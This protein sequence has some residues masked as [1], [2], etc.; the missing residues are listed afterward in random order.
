MDAVFKALETEPQNVIDSFVGPR[1]EA[2]RA[3]QVPRQ[4]M[5]Q[6]STQPEPRRTFTSMICCAG[7]GVDACLWHFTARSC[8]DTDTA[9]RRPWCELCRAC[10]RHVNDG[11]TVSKLCMCQLSTFVDWLPSR[12]VADDQLIVL[13]RVGPFPELYIDQLQSHGIVNPVLCLD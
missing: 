8:L 13:S 4:C 1:L 6:P 7:S 12:T 10:Y 11:G 9:R 3:N 5:R 2:M